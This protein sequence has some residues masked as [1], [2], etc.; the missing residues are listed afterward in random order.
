MRIRTHFV[1]A[2][3]VCAQCAMPIPTITRE[4]QDGQRHAVQLHVGDRIV[5]IES[6]ATPPSAYLNSQPEHDSNLLCTAL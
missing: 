4:G 3:R 1:T 2:E 6:R 5:L